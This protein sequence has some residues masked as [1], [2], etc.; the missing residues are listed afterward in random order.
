MPSITMGAEVAACLCILRYLLGKGKLVRMHH[1]HSTCA[2]SFLRQEELCHALDVC[3]PCMQRL[4]ERIVEKAVKGMLPSGRIGRHLFTHLKV[5]PDLL[6]G[7]LSSLGG[8]SACSCHQ[9]GV[10]VSNPPVVC[11]TP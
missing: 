3:T 2:A 9:D 7:H 5:L 11:L 8:R 1:H 10:Q 6:W 4:P